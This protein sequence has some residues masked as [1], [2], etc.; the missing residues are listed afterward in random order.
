MIPKDCEALL[1]K[2]QEWGYVATGN[3]NWKPA[4]SAQGLEVAQFFST[5]HL[6][7]ESTARFTSAWMQESTPAS[8]EAAHKSLE[9]M[10]R[11]QTCDLLLSHKLLLG[12]L[13]YRWSEA[14]RKKASAY[15]H[16]FVLNQQA[17]IAPSLARAV[18]LD[19][20]GRMAQKHMIRADAKAVKNVQTWFDSET[21]KGLKKAGD[22]KSELDQWNLSR[23]EL[24][25]SEQARERVGRLLP[26]P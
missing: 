4:S 12:L 10:S 11:A 18:Q 2:S 15:L 23:E 5:F 26:L 20:L 7:P 22:V 9:K 1:N 14:D 25:L 21:A 13:K 16:S 19:V 8:E 17:R 24:Q 6:V 3:E